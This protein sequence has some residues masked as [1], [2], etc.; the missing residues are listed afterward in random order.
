[1][2]PN[3]LNMLVFLMAYKKLWPDP[4]DVQKMLDSL[5]DEER[6]EVDELEEEEEC[7]ERY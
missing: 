4:R 2:D 6:A 1:M 7:F 5:T 3:S